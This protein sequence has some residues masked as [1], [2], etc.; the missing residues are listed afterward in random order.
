MNQLIQLFTEGDVIVF[1]V[2]VFMMFLLAIKVYWLQAELY[3]VSR[4]MERIWDKVEVK[5]NDSDDFY[6]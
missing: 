6:S 3:T 1:L 4:L 5:T 2:L